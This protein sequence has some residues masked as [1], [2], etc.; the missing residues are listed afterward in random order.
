MPAV[1]ERACYF[2]IYLLESLGEEEALL[3]VVMA[4]H[5]RVDI[6]DAR[7]S[8]LGAT[9]LLQCLCGGRSSEL[10]IYASLLYAST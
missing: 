5:R 9:V 2:T 10:N 6:P 4:D 1:S 7:E 8:A 3:H